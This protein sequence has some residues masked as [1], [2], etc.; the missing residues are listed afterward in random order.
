MKAIIFMAI[1]MCVGA[2]SMAQTV[3]LPPTT[4]MELETLTPLNFIYSGQ[5]DLLQPKVLPQAIKLKLKVKQEACLVSAQV[6]INNVESS[7]FANK[8][9]LKMAQTNSL[10]VN[11]TLGDVNLSASPALIFIQPGSDR[12]VK[13]YQYLFDLKLNPPDSFS[14]SAFTNFSIVYTIT[15]Q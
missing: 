14:G 3:D 15:L 2:R 11:R 4:T 1:L 5:Q 6:N 13:H 12:G 9:A 10:N 8:F 7:P